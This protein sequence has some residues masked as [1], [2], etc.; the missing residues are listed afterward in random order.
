MIK[1]S[2][3]PHTINAIFSHNLPPHLGKQNRIKPPAP[4]RGQ[5]FV[6]ARH[7]FLPNQRD[8]RIIFGLKVRSLRINYLRGCFHCRLL[9]PVMIMRITAVFIILI[10]EFASWER[11]CLI[12]NTK[13]CDSYRIFF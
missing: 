3:F 13:V 9:P 5:S 7:F 10:F 8:G 1:F 6:L 12:E 2:K 4:M 11:T